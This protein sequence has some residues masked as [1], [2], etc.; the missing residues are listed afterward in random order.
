MHLLS[1]L[2][3]HPKYLHGF[4]GGKEDERKNA[5]QGQISHGNANKVTTNT[6]EF[7]RSISQWNMLHHIL[8]GIQITPY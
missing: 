8:I 6:P 7:F 1:E 4:L 2:L 5:H 3:V